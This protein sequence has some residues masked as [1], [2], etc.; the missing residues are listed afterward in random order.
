MKKM[1]VCILVLLLFS[2]VN[3]Q[4]GMKLS[5]YDAVVEKKIERLLSKMTLSEK[6]G[7]MSQR[8]FWG[9][10]IAQKYKDAIRNGEVGSFLNTDKPHIMNEL[11]RIA[12]EESRLGIP[13]IFGRDV[14]H[15]FRTVFPI[16]V[17]MACSFNPD[18]VKEAA[19]VAAKETYAF[20]YRWT[21]APM[22]DVTRNPKWGRVAES[23]G[24]DSYLS[25]RMAEAL[26]K[27]FQGDTLGTPGCIAACAKHF[28]GYG[29]SEDG[30]DYQTTWIPQSELRNTYLPPFKAAVDAGVATIMSAFNDLNGTPASGNELTLKKILRG[31]WNFRGFVVSDWESVKE[32]I[33]HGYCVDEKEAAFQGLKA[34]VDMEM[35]SSCF[36][37]NAEQLIAEGKIHMA[38]IDNAVKNI[39]RIKYKIGLFDNPYID[40]AKQSDIFSGANLDVA[41]R[42]VHESV[43]MLKNNNNVLPLSKNIRKLAI[44]G[45]LADA[46][47]DQLGCWAF[48]GRSEEAVTPLQAFSD[49]LGASRIQYVAGLKYSRDMDMKEFP[50]A[51]AAA[52]SADA[53]VL[54]VGE[55]AVMSGEARCR[56]FLDLPGAQEKLIETLAASGKPLILVIMAG[57]PL[58]FEKAAER[59]TAILYA[60]HPGTMAGPGLYDL[61]FGNVSPSAKL[62]I[63]I[64]RTVGQ[65]PI[66]YGHRNTGRPASDK[67]YGI[68]TGTPLN[69]I[70]YN[71]NFL[72]VSVFPA[73]CF[74]YGLTYTSFAYSNMQLSANTIDME[75]SL[76][77]SAEIKNTGSYTATEI[78]QLYVRDIAASITRPVKELKDFTR[79]T[80]SPGE[81]KMV[82]FTI[83]AEKLAFYNNDMVYAA[84]PGDF[85]VWVAASA[86]DETLKKKFTLRR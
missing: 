42:M 4:Q 66:Y 84:E 31:E 23:C 82:S 55:E 51:L 68:P 74:G 77:V 63:T 28:V 29:A 26:V 20:G 69:P 34:G 85:Y 40:T 71:A 15:G 43:V 72:D 59:A 22:I 36:L 16:Q 53:T 33:V 78:V 17:A 57:R 11:Q 13:L 50:A 38:D 45:P 83:T 2:C 27:G 80:L 60:W 19:R 76:T 3:K 75:E 58:T 47:T 49:S 1:I 70:G 21:F 37:K 65:V 46:P 8:N 5:G 67:A 61:I 35:V 81:T 41:R 86:S 32:M 52:R 64:P 73:Y 10:T 30:K 9:D 12:V 6:L 24:E 25:A 79:L 56:A 14:I 39:L 44:I 54:F 18:M 7:Q 48:D 62:S